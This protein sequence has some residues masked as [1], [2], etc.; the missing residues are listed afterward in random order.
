MEE[1]FAYSKARVILA[2]DGLSADR[3][4][5]LCSSMGHYVY[6]FKGHEIFDELGGSF[7]MEMKRAGAARVWVDYKLHDIPQTVRLRAGKIRAWGADLLSV[8]LSGEIEMLLAAREGFRDGKVIGIS[9]LTSLDETQGYLVNGQ[10][11]AAT[12]L[13]RARLAKLAGL[14]ALVCSPQELSVLNR[15]E[16]K[17]LHLITPGIRPAGSNA[18]DQKRI[19]TPASAID[20]GATF[21]V[22]GRPIVAAA[23]PLEALRAIDDEIAVPFRTLH[24]A[25]QEA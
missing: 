18:N 25:R 19:G 14:W 10:P 23:S 15:P 7:I 17:D 22:I 20:S 24:Q 11:I 6:A 2:L 4:L 1:S 21:L 9:V 12:V 16:L 8:H 3:V 13:S 5:E